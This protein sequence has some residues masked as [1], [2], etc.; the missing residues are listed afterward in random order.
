MVDRNLID[1]APT[2]EA[3]SVFWRTLQCRQQ[4]RNPQ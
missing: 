3:A 1:L 2:R 4:Q